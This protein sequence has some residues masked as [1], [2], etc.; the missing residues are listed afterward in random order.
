M[1]P[2]QINLFSTAEPE[3][4]AAQPK[5]DYIFILFEEFASWL[6]EIFKYTIQEIKVF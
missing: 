3:Y 6:Y 4:I 1:L 5:L 2:I